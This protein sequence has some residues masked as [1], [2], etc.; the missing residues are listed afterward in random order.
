[1]KIR[2]ITCFTPLSQPV[3]EEAI[4]S[5]GDFVAHAR[6]AY[7]SAGFVVQTVRLATTPFS[8]LPAFGAGMGVEIGRAM[9]DAARQAGFEYLSLGP[10]FP[11]NL[12]PFAEIPDMLAA[13]ENLFLGGVMT[14]TDGGISLPAVRYCASIIHQVGT[15]SPDGFTNLRFAALA[16][17]PAGAPFFPA[18][19]YMD[20]EPG[21]ALALEAADLAV[22]AFSQA[23]S[24][25]AA[26]QT[27]IGDVETKAHQLEEIARQLEREHH[28]H[29]MG[30]DF[31]LAPFPQTELS[32]GTALERMG[33]PAVG[34]HG[35]LAAAAILAD[36]LDRARFLRA[37]FC[38]LMFPL[39]E[40][41]TLAMRAVEGSLTI[42]DLLLYATVCGTGLDTIPLPVNTREEQIAALLLDLAA[43]SLRLD[44][45]LTARLMP[46]P[47]KHQG[48]L[49]SYDFPYFANSRVLGVEAEP[50]RGMLAGDE[51]I[52]ITP[53][54]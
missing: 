25:H 36:T 12:A 18:A 2:S 22:E 13:T 27:L 33:V 7:E 51:I 15:L 14:T 50:L 29:F 47:G 39:L 11:E 23:P 9:E 54:K 5:M 10:A 34:L 45:P 21:F 3:D 24:L 37:G 42:K 38:G 48:D 28:H 35:S 49:T 4:H 52:T 16:N 43:L 53:H 41:Y 17:V 46:V 30:L 40:D 44:K 31:T 8:R 32:I 26:R 20:S 19:Y 1:M 6:Q